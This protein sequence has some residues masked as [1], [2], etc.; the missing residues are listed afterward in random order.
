MTEDQERAVKLIV[1]GLDLAKSSGLEITCSLDISNGDERIFGEFQDIVCSPSD[2]GSGSNEM[3]DIL[4]IDEG[5][6]LTEAQWNVLEP[7]IRKEGSQVWVAFNPRFET[8]EGFVSEW[9]AVQRGE[10]AQ[11]RKE[12]ML[13]NYNVPT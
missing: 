7:T 9:D 5:H 6:G 2:E 4:W 1:E 10:G 11:R 8:P 12:R 3:V 13:R